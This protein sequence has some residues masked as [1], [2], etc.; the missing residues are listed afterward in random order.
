MDY[1]TVKVKHR[2]FDVNNKGL[3]NVELT[4]T[5]D[6]INNIH[7]VYKQYRE[8]TIPSEQNAYVYLN[9]RTD[10]NNLLDTENK[11]DIIIDLRVGSKTLG[12]VMILIILALIQQKIKKNL[13]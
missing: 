4:D 12:L 3:E 2:L 8:N 11:N 5:Y 9:Q 1:A 7:E 10:V 6:Y 13:L